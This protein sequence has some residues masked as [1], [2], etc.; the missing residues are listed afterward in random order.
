MIGR[1]FVSL[2]A[3]ALVPA[4]AAP[5]VP[6]L[7]FSVA[8]QYDCAIA[9]MGHDVV[10][11]EPAGASEGVQ[12]PPGG[13]QVSVVEMTGPGIIATG[14]W[15]Y[16]LNVTDDGT[17]SSVSVPIAGSTRWPDA[18]E[19][20]VFDLGVRRYTLTTGALVP[21]GQK[22]IGNAL[23]THHAADLP[24]L[25]FAQGPGH[26]PVGSPLSPQPVVAMCTPDGAVDTS[27]SGQVTISV[28]PAVVAGPALEGTR[29]VQAVAGVA[30]F[31]D[32]RISE[33]Q[34]G[35]VLVA[36]SGGHPAALSEP[37]DV[38]PV[39]VRLAF[40]RQPAG[41][42]QPLAVQPVVTALDANGNTAASYSGPVS[43]SIKAGT[44]EPGAEITG[45][46]SVLAVAGVA[47]FAD[48]GIDREGPRTSSSRTAVTSSPRRA[49]HSGLRRAPCACVRTATMR[50][51]DWVGRRRSVP[52]RRRS[53]RR[54]R[55]TRCGWPQEPTRKTSG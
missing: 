54:G 31:Q 35:V 37:F 30:T 23:L 34:P 2:L 14:Y 20:T 15:R 42:G 25:A 26:T 36:S 49:S 10:C 5:S 21:D 32:L 55:V 38:T 11:F 22:R 28:K 51:L 50:P 48:V 1:T 16:T 12:V 43:L 9:D 4:L 46:A 24:V 53:T 18:I 33:I 8:G 6:S 41:P 3:L 7:S 39:P 17:G 29:T 27:F 19:P 52:C 13:A 44:G 47:A 45:Q 40:V